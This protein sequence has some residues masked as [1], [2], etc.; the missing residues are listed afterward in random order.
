MLKINDRVNLSELKQYGFEDTNL[1]YYYNDSRVAVIVK[2][3]RYVYVS[4]A[5]QTFTDGT[6]KI[7]KIKSTIPDIIYKLIAA[8][9]IVSEVYE[10]VVE[11]NP[12]ETTVLVKSSL[13]LNGMDLGLDNEFIKKKLTE[14]LATKINP[15]F[16]AK[17]GYYEASIKVVVD[18]KERYGEKVRRY[19][20]KLGLTSRELGAK[21]GTSQS[22][23]SR[24]EN[25]ADDPQSI[26]STKLKAYFEH[27]GF[28]LR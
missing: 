7:Y 16:Y 18:N 12:N 22:T 4:P 21:I 23:I 13:N 15:R 24:L 26:S 6:G 20:E 27:K 19:R 11:N 14:N 9:I 17:D 2:D 5:H 8:N 28:D 10:P 25:E 1:G 3:N